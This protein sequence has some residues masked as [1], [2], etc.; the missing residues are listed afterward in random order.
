MSDQSGTRGTPDENI[1]NSRNLAGCIMRTSLASNVLK[2]YNTVMR[3]VIVLQCPVKLELDDLDLNL[4][5]HLM[6]H[7]RSIPV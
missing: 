3:N 1:G 4:L 6:L 2:R 5:I 7:G